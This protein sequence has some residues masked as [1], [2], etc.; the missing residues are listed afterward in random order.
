MQNQDSLNNMVINLPKINNEERQQWLEELKEKDRVIS[1]LKEEAKAFQEERENHTRV[2]HELKEEL[3]STKVRAMDLQNNLENEKT[4]VKKVMKLNEVCR[5][6]SDYRVADICRYYEEKIIEEQ[7]IADDEMHYFIEKRDKKWIKR[8]EE[9]E[10]SQKDQVGDIYGSAM[11]YDLNSELKQE[12]KILKDLY[13]KERL[14]KVKAEEE[15]IYLRRENTG[16]SECVEDLQHEVKAIE[17]EK[18]RMLGIKNREINQLQN[19]LD[20]QNLEHE[21]ERHEYITEINERKR[22]ADIIQNEIADLRLQIV[23]VNDLKD[24]LAKKKATRTPHEL[25]SVDYQRE[26]EEESETE[27]ETAPVP[28]GKTDRTPSV[29]PS[30]INT[31]SCSLNTIAISVKP[32]HSKID[33]G[34]PHLKDQLEKKMVTR[35]PHEV[36]TVEEESETEDETAS[37]ETYE[38]FRNNQPQAKKKVTTTPYELF[39]VDYQPKQEE[40]SETEDETAPVPQGKT[41]RTPSVHPSDINTASCSLNTTAICVKPYHSKIDGGSPHLK[42]QLEKKMVTRPPHE[43][44]TVEEESETEDE[45]APVETYESFRNNQPQAEKKVTTTPYELFSV[46]YQ[47]KQEEESETEDETAP[48]ETSKSIAQRVRSFFSKSIFKGQ[49]K[50]GPQVEPLSIQPEVT[51]APVPQGKTDRTPSVHPSDINTASC[52]LNTTAICVKPYH[53]KIDGGSPHLKDQLEKKM[54]TRPPHEVFS[55]EEESETEDETASVE[56]YE[57]FR[58]NQP[59][60]EKKVTTTP[61][62]LFSVN[63]QPKQEEESET[64]DETAPVETSKS[65]AQRVRS[66]F[67]KSVFPRC[68]TF[69]PEE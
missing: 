20:D 25:F 50:V 1:S 15:L 35:P 5:E 34:S 23:Q 11:L 45:T 12:V 4:R 41:D 49:N 18:Q 13:T 19:Q 30:D 37:V 38:S 6:R 21:A 28:Q 47:P 32:Y 9:I 10:A 16:P 54:V 64:E 24:Q 69:G 22:F 14:D 8:I 29:H 58:N 36:F 68:D 59:Q 33:G 57:S 55:E 40:E 60:A 27:D 53:S 44:F 65:F 39:S 56:T 26:Q 46:N 66:F 52:S 2:I 3:E 67:S 51:D 7:Q 42:D 48:V 61:N 62:E 63:Y 17:R 31:A 43:V